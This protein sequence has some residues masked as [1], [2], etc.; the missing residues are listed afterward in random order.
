ML[1]SC[2]AR[3]FLG[4]LLGLLDHVDME[5]AEDFGRLS[6][7]GRRLPRY[8]RQAVPPVVV[9]K[10]RTGAESGT[11]CRTLTDSA[12]FQKPHRKLR[13]ADDGWTLQQDGR[14]AMKVPTRLRRLSVS[15]TARE[16]R[17]SG[18]PCK[19]GGLAEVR[20]PTHHKSGKR[21]AGLVCQGA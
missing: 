20:L 15:I 2:P 5:L 8:P 14:L 18:E 10:C 7:S 1:D 12:G 9:E 13:A 19:N 3:W 6:R 4:P 21:R 16:K 11:L 17:P